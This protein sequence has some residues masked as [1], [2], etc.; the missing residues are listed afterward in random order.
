[1]VI[2][3]GF[4]IHKPL[5]KVPENTLKY[6][7]GLLLSSFGVFWLGEGLGFPWWHEDISLLV[8][9]AAFLIT[10]QIGVAIARPKRRP[11]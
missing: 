1:M 9:L 3:L 5:A 2:G 8:I 11:A 6:A 7:V 4:A 10:S